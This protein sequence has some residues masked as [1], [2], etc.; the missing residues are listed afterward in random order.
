M[1]EDRL[2]GRFRPRFNLGIELATVNPYNLNHQN[3]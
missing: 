1:P 3:L 2:G